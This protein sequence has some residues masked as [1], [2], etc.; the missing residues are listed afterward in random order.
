MKIRT[1]KPEK[2]NKYYIKK[3]SGGYSPCI[4]G[5]PTDK[6]CNVLSNCVGYAVGRFNEEINAGKCKYL[7]SCNAENFIRY[8]PKL[9][10]GKTA[11]QGAVMCWQGKG[12]KAGHVAIVE[13]VISETEVFTSESA[14]GGKPFYNKTRKKGNGNWGMNSDYVFNGFLYNPELPDKFN[15]TRLL[16][17]GCKGNDVKELQK[18]LMKRG[19][20]VGKCGIDGKFGNDTQKAV[21]NYQKD[22]KLIIDGVVGKNTA[23]SLD[24]LY[25]GK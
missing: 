19:Y 13:K 9:K 12:K 14:Y 7:K 16:K 15:L 6:D 11:K 20:D 18:E 21:K 17:K 23:H 25:K 4:T 1:T 24:W 2:D 22:N 5:K 10:N 8:N 3:S